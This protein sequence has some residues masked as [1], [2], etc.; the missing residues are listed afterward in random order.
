MIGREPELAAADVF[1]DHL[2][3]GAGAFA[4]EGEAGIGKTALLGEI[5]ERAAARS[6]AVLFCRPAEVETKLSF[7]SL[8][9]LLVGVGD[10]VVRGLPSVQRR[11]L[12][13]ALLR[14]QPDGAIDHRAVSAAVVSTLVA[15]ARERPVVVAIDDA[16]W[17]DAASAR[18]LGFAARRIGAERI[19][20][21][22]SVRRD[23]A[24]PL[25][26]GLELAFSGERLERVALGPLSRGALQRL[27]GARLVS[28]F[29]RPVL[30]RIERASGGNPF[31]ALEIGRALGAAPAADPGSPLWVPESLRELVVRRVSALGSAAREALLVAAALARPTVELLDRASSAAGVAA[32]EESGLLRVDRGQVSFAHPLYASAVY[33]AAATSRRRRLHRRL[34][35]VVREPEERARHLALAVEGPDEEVAAVL[36]EAARGARSR[37]AWDSAGE[38]SERASQLTSPD[39]RDHAWRR[40]LRAA[41]DHVHAGDRPRAR[42]LLEEILAEALPRP[43]RAEALCLLG[44]ISVDDK[45]LPVAMRV[46]ASALEHA[47]DARLASR[48]ENG[49]GFVQAHMMDHAAGFE[50]SR[51][52]LELAEA[53]GDRA[54]TGEALSS[55]AMY[56]FLSGR[57]VDW[58]M[59]ERSLELEDPDRVRAIGRPSLIAAALMLY[60]GRPEARERLLA[61]RDMMIE[62][63]DESD[64]AFVAHWLC[65][66]ERRRANLPAAAAWAED[67][68]ELAGLTGSRSMY[69]WALSQRALVHACR[70]EITETRSACAEVDGLIERDPAPTPKLWVAG[71]LALLELSLGNAAAAWQA[72]EA[73]TEAVE[74][75]G[76]GEPVMVEFLPD[77]LDALVALGQLDR[78]EALLDTLEARGHEVDRAWALAT[79]GRCRGL[80]LA[81]RGDLDGAVVV[82]ER[83]L[84]EHQRLEM[85]FEL[86]RTLLVHGQVRRRR[87][88]KRLARESL[89]RSLEL[90]GE[91]GAALWAERASEQIA[92]LG[93]RTA[94]GEL[95]WTE[96]RVAELAGSGMI[97]KEIAA[98][99]FVSPRTVQANLVR[100]YDK[101]GIRTRAELG[102]LIAEH[103]EAQRELLQT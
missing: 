95:T 13:G 81:A 36:E 22:I 43:V 41:E 94:P 98:A 75:N 69:A 102:A 54:L 21:V 60:V 23:A 3:G 59:V 37:G 91:I 76:I 42:A 1:L 16:Q 6:Y 34:A 99:L 65:W 80:L 5:V 103:G 79:G 25:P 48:I 28:R 61:V 40:G 77:A 67:A 85:P 64:L 52:A 101:L 7:V 72:C 73:L 31:F 89:V 9:D 24:V 29:P 45:A 2:R 56:G 32:A 39:R 38:L 18:A 11:A 20:F 27:L 19:G 51:R 63:G 15:V 55:C 78:A 35:A 93:L 97:N 86:A 92:R 46:Y 70:G 50:H 87:R 68:A 66:L 83:A 30:L 47:D 57:G 74:Q 49:L 44:E 84:V 96:R 8:S 88:Q 53:S 26:L 17:L 14:R 62:R 10:D 90:F 33:M 4:L 71:A 12:E 58:G 100:V 82:L